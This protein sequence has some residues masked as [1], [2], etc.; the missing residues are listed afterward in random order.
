FGD[1]TMTVTL[2][3]V[4]DLKSLNR[5]DLFGNT[6]PLTWKSTGKNTIQVEVPI[7]DADPTVHDLNQ[8]ENEDVF[9]L[10]LQQG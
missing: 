9:Y 4:H 10:S 7:I 8:T 6:T 2:R 1:P 5:V 3:N